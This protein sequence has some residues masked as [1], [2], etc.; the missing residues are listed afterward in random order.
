ME[1]M[2]KT[3][4]VECADGELK[5]RHSEAPGY[6]ACVQVDSSELAESSRFRV[7]LV[8]QSGGEQDVWRPTIKYAL[9]AA[10]ELLR[11]VPRRAVTVEAARKALQEFCEQH[12]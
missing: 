8:G 4:D 7:I 5:V 9:E 3:F 6:Y 1:Y 12:G 2:G 11:S 10:F